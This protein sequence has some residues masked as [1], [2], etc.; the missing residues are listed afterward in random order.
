MS[1]AEWR[2]SPAVLGEMESS[3]FGLGTSWLPTILKGM[4]LSPLLF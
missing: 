1:L 4:E 2:V 3:V